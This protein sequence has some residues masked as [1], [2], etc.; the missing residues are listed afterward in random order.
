[1]ARRVSRG[2][3]FPFTVMPSAD[4]QDVPTDITGNS[5]RTRDYSFVLRSRHQFAFKGMQ[6]VADP[7]LNFAVMYLKVAD[8]SMSQT[9][10]GIS[11][12]EKDET[13][14]FRMPRDAAGIRAA[15]ERR[16]ATAGDVNAGAAAGNAA[17]AEPERNPKSLA[18]DHVVDARYQR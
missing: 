6:Y 13:G 16:R 2:I 8:R 10:Y 15:M 12:L 7:I 18:R 4:G 14:K 1:M 9:S 11:N 17:A 5:N 3:P